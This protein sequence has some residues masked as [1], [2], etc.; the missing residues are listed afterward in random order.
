MQVKQLVHRELTLRYTTWIG[1][2][3]CGVNNDRALIY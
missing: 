1:F 2:G 3:V